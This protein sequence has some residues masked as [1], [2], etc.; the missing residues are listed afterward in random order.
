MGVVC[1]RSSRNCAVTTISSSAPLLSAGDA[2]RAWPL[3]AALVKLASKAART[4]T[5]I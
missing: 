4:A 3:T 1:S 5:R 2:A